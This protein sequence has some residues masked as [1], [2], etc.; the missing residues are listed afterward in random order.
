MDQRSEV[1][2]VVFGAGEMQSGRSL[3]QTPLAGMHAENPAAKLGKLQSSFLCTSFVPVLRSQLEQG[4]SEEDLI[5]DWLC[6]NFTK[7]GVVDPGS[8]GTGGGWKE[9]DG[10]DEEM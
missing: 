10:E 5:G 3:V 8:V 2:T 9:I 4:A 7:L 6:P 1:C